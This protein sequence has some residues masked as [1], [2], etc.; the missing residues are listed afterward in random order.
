MAIEKLKAEDYILIILELI[1]PLFSG[2]E[3]LDFLLKTGK[4]KKIPVVILTNLQQ[5]DDIKRLLQYDIT[6]YYLK[7]N[8]DMTTF[9]ANMREILANKKVL[10]SQEE[11][12][13]LTTR[14]L[15]LS[16][17]NSSEGTPK[18]KVL[19]CKKCE[20]TLPPKTEFCPYCG[21]KVETEEFI[22][23]NY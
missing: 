13:F 12:D 7:S 14:L 8:V 1:V 16:Q 3:I 6:D 19:K 22:K 18:V 2:Y 4:Y 9:S 15:S 11:K 10:M 17:Q 23:Q 5:E 20:A 21:T